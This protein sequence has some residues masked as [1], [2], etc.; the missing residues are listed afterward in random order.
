MHSS[1]YYKLYCCNNQ[2][3]PSP[4]TTPTPKSIQN[5]Q[6][7]PI[8]VFQ[9]HSTNFKINTVATTNGIQSQIQLQLQNPSKTIKSIQSLFFRCTLQILKI[10]TVATTNGIQVPIQ[11]QLQNQSKTLKS[12]QTHTN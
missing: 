5:H 8:P 7:D 6:I 2:R 11:L 10:N 4:N 12:M 1:N 9:M 3:Y